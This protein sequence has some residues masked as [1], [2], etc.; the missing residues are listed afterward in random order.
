M[1]LC[2]KGNTPR[3]VVVSSEN[4][5]SVQRRTSVVALLRGRDGAPRIMRRKGVLAPVVPTLPARLIGSTFRRSDVRGP[6][7][8]RVANAAIRL[9]HEI[10]RN[11][12]TLSRSG[13]NRVEV[14]VPAH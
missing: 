3:S 12:E 2:E 9:S 10:L 14:F 7:L 6:D 5:N 4:G 8:T 11:D 13:V 1:Q